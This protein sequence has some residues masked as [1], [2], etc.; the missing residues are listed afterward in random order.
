MDSEKQHTCKFQPEIGRGCAFCNE[1]DEPEAQPCGGCLKLHETDWLEEYPDNVPT[2]IF[3]I[4]RA[5]WRERVEMGGVG[6]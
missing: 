2:D 4:G 1:G 6:G 3:E 5:S